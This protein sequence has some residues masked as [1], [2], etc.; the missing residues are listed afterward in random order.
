MTGI[1]ERERVVRKQKDLDEIMGNFKDYIYNL[2]FSLDKYTGTI[3]GSLNKTYNQ[4]IKG[5]MTKENSTIVSFLYGEADNI[6]KMKELK[7]V[8]ESIKLLTKKYDMMLSRIVKEPNDNVLYEFSVPGIEMFSKIV[9]D[10]NWT[11]ISFSVYNNDE[12]QKDDIYEFT[13]FL[14]K[15]FKEFEQ[16]G[17]DK[18]KSTLTRDE[19]IESFKDLNIHLNSILNRLK[20]LA[21]DLS[22]P[23]IGALIVREIIKIMVLVYMVSSN[24]K[25]VINE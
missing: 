23:A 5:K 19:I 6:I 13:K 8:I 16:K 20:T 3:Y 15:T 2:V 25:F 18:E 22:S 21:E 14:D 1:E 24:M 7:F 10:I 12:T 4:L 17:F 11:N 9:D